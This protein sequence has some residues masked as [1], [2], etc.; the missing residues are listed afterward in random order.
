MKNVLIIMSMLLSLGM[1]CTCT[2]DDILKGNVEV[3]EGDPDEIT[4]TLYNKW[5][6][7]S[8]GNKSNEVLKEAKG[9]YYLITFH[10]DGTYSGMAYGNEMGG[11]FKLNGKEIRINRVNI[12]KFKWEGSDP[13]QFFLEHLTDVYTYTI[14]DMELRLYYSKDQYFKFRIKND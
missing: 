1:F 8:Y 6:L 10:P 4:T 2:S 12:T 14:T 13:D 3:Q 11:E 7:V 9:Y 5:V